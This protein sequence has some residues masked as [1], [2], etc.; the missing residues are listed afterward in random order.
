MKTIFVTGGNG[1]IGSRVVRLLIGREY[2]VRCL[3]RSTS[4]THRIDDLPFERVEGDVRQ[5]DSLKAGMAG[6]DGVLHLA[7]LSNWSDIHSP[8]MREVVIDG[9]RHVFQAAQALG[10]LP[11]VYVSSS[12]AINGT[13]QPQLLDETS[14]FTLNPRPYAY[15]AAKHA[16]E[17]MGRA[18]VGEG[19]PIRIVNPTEVYGPFDYELITSGNLVDFAKSNPVLVTHGGT[20]VV[21]VDDVASGILAALERGKPGE[22]YILGGDNLS[23]REI[24]E[25]TLRI[26]GQQKTILTMPNPVIQS[27]AWLG[28][29][30]RIPM[31][32][33]P[34]VIP[35][36]IKYWYISNRKA[37]EQLG[38]QFRTPEQ[39]LRPT[40][41][42][43]QDEGYIPVGQGAAPQKSS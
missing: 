3:L 42:W 20:S 18:F 8:R 33:N 43:L 7:S 21:Y 1:F 37:S 40:L 26:L 6:C 25:L 4:K 27:L 16:V 32:F 22:R 11:V 31:P 38:L 28:A 17:A 39:T 29:N 14:T 35:Y 9:S 15:A 12:T 19:V 34:A 2:R 5:L 41:E 30:L 23:V 13:E 24:A 36:A 10:N